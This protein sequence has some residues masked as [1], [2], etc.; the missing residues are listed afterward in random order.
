MQVFLDG[1]DDFC[2]KYFRVL[3]KK[4]IN[5]NNTD[6]QLKFVGE[7]HLHQKQDAYFSKRNFTGFQPTS[8]GL[9]PDK[10]NTMN[11]ERKY[12]IKNTNMQYLY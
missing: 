11:D 5:I 8:N 6:I 7:A 3:L 1:H 10:E 4:Y 9:R 12:R 2:Q